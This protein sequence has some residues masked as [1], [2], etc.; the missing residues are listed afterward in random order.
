MA[1]RGTTA[2]HGY[3]PHMVMTGRKIQ[4]PEAFWFDIKTPHSIDPLILN[5]SWVSNLLMSIQELHLDTARKLALEQQRL[6]KRLGWAQNP[7]QWN[8]GQCGLCRKFFKNG[9]AL[10]AKWQGPNQI[11]HWV[12]PAIYQL[13]IP[14]KKCLDK[15]DIHQ[16]SMGI[17]WTPPDILLNETFMVHD[18]G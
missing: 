1:I 14:H 5:N 6:D 9:H 10:A 16:I 17:P 7:Q 3:T 4:L 13:A 18:P 2:V 15:G 8:P 11:V 12:T